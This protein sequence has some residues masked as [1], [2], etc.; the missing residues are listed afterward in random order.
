MATLYKVN[1]DTETVTPKKD[2]LFSLE[3]M[4][5]FVGGYIEMVA[6][7]GDVKHASGGKGILIVNEEGLMMGLPL[8]RQ[9]SILAHRPIVGDAL[10]ATVKGAGTNRE[11]I[12]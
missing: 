3:E 6:I 2:L 9:A 12:Y 8:N 5:A 11:T 10:Y 1:G 7:P 4:Q